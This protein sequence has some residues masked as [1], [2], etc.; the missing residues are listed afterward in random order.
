MTGKIIFCG[1]ICAF[2]WPVLIYLKQKEVKERFQK[3]SEQNG[4]MGE[5]TYEA[6]KI[7]LWILGFIAAATL[8]EFLAE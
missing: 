5:Y 4:K 3:W 6:V 8:I 1:I 2:V 7:S